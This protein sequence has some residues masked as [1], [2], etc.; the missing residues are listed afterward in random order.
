MIGAG[1]LAADSRRRWR[2]RS[3]PAAIR[4]GKP[5]AQ[6][7]GDG[8]VSRSRAWRAELRRLP[9]SRRETRLGTRIRPSGR[10]LLRG[11]PVADGRSCDLGRGSTRPRPRA[12][13][14]ATGTL[15]SARVDGR[16]PTRRP[17]PARLAPPARGTAAWAPAGRAAGTAAS[18]GGAAGTG[19]GAAA[20]GDAGDAAGG[21][22]AEGGGTGAGV[23]GADGG[24]ASGRAGRKSS[25]ST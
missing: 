16:E 1:S 9:R 21:T 2:A 4:R 25:G 19:V 10:Q 11:S 12:G 14:S 18:R 7:N 6:G 24:G 5:A 8:P 3:A 13:T 17:R 22:G 15:L 23:G 20:G